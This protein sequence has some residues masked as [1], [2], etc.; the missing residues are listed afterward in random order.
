MNYE[1]KTCFKDEDSVDDAE[2]DAE[3]RMSLVLEDTEGYSSAEVISLSK[4]HPQ[5]VPNESTETLKMESEEES[6]ARKSRRN[7]DKALAE[8]VQQGHEMMLA[9][10]RGNGHE[11]RLL[12]A[13]LSPSPAS[14]SA[15]DVRQQLMPMHKINRYNTRST[16]M[17]DNSSV[18]DDASLDGNIDLK[19]SGAEERTVQERGAAIGHHITEYNST[20]TI[21]TIDTIGNYDVHA[22]RQDFVDDMKIAANTQKLSTHPS[23][24]VTRY[25]TLST[26]FD[27]A[28]SPRAAQQQQAVLDKYNI[29]S[30]LATESS[31]TSSGV[32]GVTSS[33]DQAFPLRRVQS[34][35]ELSTNDVSEEPRKSP[36]SRVGNFFRGGKK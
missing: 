36:L 17:E 24:T 18:V 33:D 13:S 23:H 32:S 7:A 12:D 27:D 2:T 30:F 21:G 35:I 29:H 9:R 11:I 22:V 15:Y 25:N 5:V 4:L 14:C 8:L 34:S 28:E 3:K 26:V 1:G 6:P 19:S 31:A 16:V 10:N 20:S